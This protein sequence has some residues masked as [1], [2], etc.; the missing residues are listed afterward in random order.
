M[1]NKKILCL[2]DYNCR[3]GFGTV[4]KQIKKHI[5]NHFGNDIS[6][7]I[8]A[9]N[10]HGDPYEES[11]G[12]SVIS[13]V[14]SAPKRDD[15]GRYGFLKLL[16]DNDYDGIFVMQDLAVMKPIY[17]IIQNV[18][19]YKV[20]NGKKQFK[21][22]FYFP[23]DCH[24]SPQYLDGIE[25]FDCLVTYTEYGRVEVLNVKESLRDKLRVIGHGVD[26]NVF[27]PLPKEDIEGFKEA[28]FGCDADTYVVSNVNRNQARKDIPK[29]IS[30]FNEFRSWFVKYTDK[31]T[32]LYLHMLP[33]DPMGWDLRKVLEQYNLKEGVDYKFPEGD[34]LYDVN[35]TPHL[36]NKIYN[37][38]DLYITTTL[39]EGWGL[40]V[41]E[42]AAA[43]CPIV[44]PLVTSLQS[45]FISGLSGWKYEPKEPMVLTADNTVRYVGGAKEIAIQIGTAYVDTDDLELKTRVEQSYNWAISLD[46]KE[47][48][49]KWIDLFKEIY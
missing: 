12:T 41:H 20:Q 18:K 35:Y 25:V 7:D 40:T 11:D 42:A 43:K 22:I 34:I 23:V 16:K 19:E 32:L 24:I 48:C 5:K 15:F 36:L 2:F 28:Y 27:K 46:W 3:T 39:G 14:K 47:I 29:T 44:F 1:K 21:S 45:M 26:T 33:N 38:S 8:V 30:A 6:F 4:S 10:Y 9:I 13:A 17:K 37:A 31:K 49:K